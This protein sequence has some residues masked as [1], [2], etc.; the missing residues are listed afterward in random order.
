MLAGAGVAHRFVRPGVAM[1]TVA[2]A[3]A[4][5][6]APEAAIVKTIV[7]EAPDGSHVAAVAAG[8]TRIDR[9][10]LA[11]VAGKQSLAVADPKT[12]LRI[13]GF[14][15]GGVAPVGHATR[16]PVV[17]DVGVISLA[18]VWGGGGDENLLLCLAPKDIVQLSAANVADIRAEPG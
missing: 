14:P 17:V 6:D 8:R 11:S 13:T 1:P 3:A 9:R 2:A 18:Q 16:I 12:V 5:I 7:F 4:A 10:K 15:V